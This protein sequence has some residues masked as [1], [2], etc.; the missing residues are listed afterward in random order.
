VL[1]FFLGT[2]FNST[3]LMYIRR[4]FVT[5]ACKVVEGSECLRKER[6]RLKESVCVTDHRH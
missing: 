6:F 5:S 2:K 3:S 1:F 4:K